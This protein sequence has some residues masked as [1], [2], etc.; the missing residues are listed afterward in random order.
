[1]DSPPPIIHSPRLYSSSDGSHIVTARHVYLR[2]VE[3]LDKA[4]ELALTAARQRAAVAVHVIRKPP[5]IY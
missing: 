4:S 5:N 2:Q 1:M 3:L